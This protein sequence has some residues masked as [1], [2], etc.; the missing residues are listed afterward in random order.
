MPA[1]RAAAEPA[2]PAPKRPVRVRKTPTRLDGNPV[3]RRGRP[4]S[5]QRAPSPQRTPEPPELMDAAAF[6]VSVTDQMADMDGVLQ[7]TV[8]RFN[9]VDGRLDTLSA[10]IEALTLRI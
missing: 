2:A 5:S 10:N 7:D 1:K 8:R 9:A 3:A 6:Q 4:P